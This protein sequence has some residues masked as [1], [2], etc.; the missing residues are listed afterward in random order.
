[1]NMSDQQKKYVVYEQGGI[2][3][4]FNLLI[5]GFL[6]WLLFK[7]Y[8]YIP[9]YGQNPSVVIDTLMTLFLLGIILPL[10]VIPIARKAIRKKPQLQT[11]MSRA[12]DPLVRLLP[13][14]LLLRC[15]LFGSILTAAVLPLFL[16]AFAILGISSLGSMDYVIFKAIYT[17]IAGGVLAVIAVWSAVYDASET[18]DS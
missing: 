5:N 7:S 10:C 2:S 17:G 11:K 12:D 16:L 4:I 18:S 15:L 1:M 6:A 13:T 14:N 9:V 3:V 8:D